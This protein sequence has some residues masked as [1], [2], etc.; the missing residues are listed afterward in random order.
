MA[1]TI[2]ARLGPYEIGPLVGSGGMG[3]VYRARDPRLGR[4]VAIKVLPTTLS[5]DPDRLRRFEQE[6][7]SAAALNHPG[8]LAVYDI[9]TESGTPYIVSELLEGE[10]LRERLKRGSSPTA[11]GSGGDSA[12]LAVRKAVDYALQVARGLSAAHEKGIIHRDLK[13]ENLFITTDGR[14]KILDFGLAKLT[15]VTAAL[16]GAGTLPTTPVGT[17]PG[18]MLGTMGYMAPEQ[19]R[20]QNTDHR[21]DI[22]AFGAILHE[23]LSGQRAFRGATTA[24]TISA[25]LDKDPADLPMA[26]RHI[27]PALERV[28]DRCL[29]KSPAARF[30]ST[31]DLAFALDGLSNHSEAS[32][33]ADGAKLASKVAPGRREKIAW[34]TAGALA[35]VAAAGAWL[36]VRRPVERRDVIRF[37]IQT[38]PGALPVVGATWSGAVSPDGRKIVFTAGRRAGQQALWIRSLDSLDAVQLPGTEHSGPA[39]IF[40]SPDSRFIGFFANGKLRKLDISGGAPQTLCDAPTNTGGTW[41]RD[42][43]I[44]FGATNGGL[45]RVPDA[46]GQPVPATTLDASRSETR[47]R[48]PSFLP[49]G[50]RFTYLAQPSNT[51]FVGSLDSPEKTQ[52]LNAD[53]G[54]MYSAGY[55]VFLRQATAFAQAFDPGRL[56]VTGEAVP[57]AERISSNASAG[58]GALFASETGVLLDVTG[59]AAQFSAQ[60]AWFDR[61]GKTLGSL[62][63]PA[64]YRGI[65]LSPDDR[66]LAEHPHENVGGGDLWL[67]DLTRETTT[68]FTFGAHNTGPVWSPDGARIAFGSNRPASGQPSGDPYGGSFDLYEKS[69]DG[70]GEMTVLLDS[71]ANKLPTGWKQ[72][73]SWSPDGQL[74]VFDMIDPKTS[75]DIWAVPLTGDRKP[76]P[77]VQ[78]EFQE[79]QGQISPD[80]RWLAYLSNETKRMEVYV[81]SMSG[82]AGKWQISTQGGAY[83]KWRHDGKEL[84]YLSRDRKLMAVDISAGGRAVEAGI[85]HPLFDLRIPGTF[86]STDVFAP[87]AN[88][89]YPYAVTRDGQR[90]L[91]SMDV[92][93]LTAETPITVTVNWMA[94]LKK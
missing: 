8:I 70:T 16:A 47:H 77:L 79:A 36:L 5:A 69:A 67:R 94:G 50:R 27:P 7:R 51:V 46:G 82:S 38:P 49:D 40:W 26:E 9:G 90:F 39:G 62:G 31:H 23:M 20:G 93:Q 65:E 72:P 68:R 15:E 81:R 52:L 75:F 2:G 48:S 78:T 56:K 10:T 86:V 61:A 25:I 11:V 53:S 1:L 18:V 29:E 17:E 57:I 35:V 4:D 55:L 32:A 12:G 19:L 74:L 42:G 21:S 13:P 44:V 41:N 54:A 71:V 37:P 64:D 76:R 63:A 66:R 84:F 83:P 80:G 59:V 73:T 85:P 60:L 34:A 87:N 43:V 58:G 22:F 45:L 91:V 89:P 88:T 14:V 6:A 30:Q 3:E 28:V 92:S 24:D 33:V